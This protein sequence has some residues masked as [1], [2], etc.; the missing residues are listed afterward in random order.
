MSDP[1]RRVSFLIPAQPTSHV[2]A[3]IFEECC[4]SLAETKWEAMR[5]LGHIAHPCIEW[6]STQVLDSTPINTILAHTNCIALSGKLDQAS[7]NGY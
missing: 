3:G 7:L 5:T 4:I 6:S 2:V 1:S